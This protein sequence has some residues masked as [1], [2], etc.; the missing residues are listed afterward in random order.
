MNFYRLALLGGFASTA[1]AAGLPLANP[2]FEEA[3]R[4]WTLSDG[5]MSFIS[6]EAARSG[7]AGLLVVDTDAAAG[8]SARSAYL[9]A[10]ADESYQ[11]DFQ[12][13]VI[14]GSGIAVYLQFFDRNRKPLTG[15]RKP[16]QILRLIPGHTEAWA[17]FTLAATAPEGTASLSVWVHSF[18]GSRVKACLD[19]FALKTIPATAVAA[20]LSDQAGTPDALVAWEKADAKQAFADMKVLQ[21]DGTPVRTP[22]EDWEGARRRVAADPA[23]QKWLRAK[24]AK[25]DAW[26]ARHRDR[27]EWE[28]G[29]NH[30]F[31]SPTD[32]GFLV[33]TEN[34]P[35]EETDHFT[36]LS[37][38]RVEITPTLFRAWV[39][40]FRKRHAEQAIEVARLYRLTGESR[41]AEWVAAQ[42]DFYA[43]NHGAWGKGV[44]KRAHSWLGYQS[45]D[46]AVIVSRLT[47]A[48]RLVFDHVEPARR[49]HWFDHLFKPEAELLDK[50]FHNIHNIALWQRATQAKIALLY[51]DE[52]MWARVVDGAHGVRDQFRRGVTND[53]FWYEQSM[54]YNGFVVMAVESLFSF[55]GLLGQGDRL[56]HEAAIMQNLML[57][58]FSIRFPDGSLPN[59]ADTT[60]VPRISTGGLEATYRF[61]PTKLG[62]ARA[63][64][65][66]S[67]DTLLDPPDLI[68]PPA[69][70]AAAPL[71]EV[72]SR[73]MEST[74]FALMRKG[75]W[76]VFFHYGQSNRSHA[77]AE[78]LNWSASFDG[79]DISHDS[80]TVAYGS[81]LS[82]GYYRQGLAHNIPLVA[83]EGQ[84]P[85]GRGELLAFDAD[86]GR[87]AVAQPAY[88]PG[89]AS[90]QRELR[91]EGDALIDV[92][93]VTLTSPDAKPV[94]LG[95]ALHLQGTPRVGS[96]FAD[97]SDGDFAAGRPQSF[98]YW[99]DVR[100]AT[101]R[102]HAVIP[103]EFA[104]GRVLDVEFV[105]DGEFTLHLGSAPGQPPK[106]HTGF[107]L[108]TAPAT[109]A[110][111]RTT[112]SPA[113]PR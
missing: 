99:T 15:D 82:G 47:D 8:S 57:A 62:L 48:A 83:G 75:L 52:V 10:V 68:Y 85:W 31:V 89:V 28:A 49:Q 7:A 101:F 97:V 39:G 12:A 17:A 107:Y 86:A 45:L 109:H 11:L 6:S 18:N 79:I 60:G 88:R 44:G 98:R 74:R 113:L 21:P 30:D 84:K 56:A 42:L 110:A 50:S 32:G 70:A 36:S 33:W 40:A 26:M 53:Y 104:D 9:P 81:P 29:W 16:M 93:S 71:P 4:G 63:G 2:G 24:Q 35:G 96:G 14:N 91:I 3:T 112:L 1:F 87:M 80:G 61:L 22:I 34:I 25:S 78:A 92:A 66:V 59:P 5:G 77:Q 23:A 55:T 108:E 72:V 38:E 41:Y 102:D 46:D 111:F 64:R 67:W 27:T 51:G 76:Q 73:N 90:A 100:K 94:P 13:K 65:S 58:P 69:E 20:A 106:R 54:G 43:D 19:D 37:G 103:V 95:L 105:H